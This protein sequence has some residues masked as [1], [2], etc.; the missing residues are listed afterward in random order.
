MS[1]YE[2]CRKTVVPWMVLDRCN[3]QSIFCIILLRGAMMVPKER[4]QLW[5][6]ELVTCRNGSIL[7]SSDP[8][9]L[10]KC[11]SCT[12]LYTH[13]CIHPPSSYFVYICLRVISV[14]Y[15]SSVAFSFCLTLVS[16]HM[17]VSLALFVC[18]SL[19][20]MAVSVAFLMFVS[21]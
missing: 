17:Y 5:S 16:F 2:V 13:G 7:K 6:M 4:D 10:Y 21:F 12:C 3:H 9:S 20:T 8:Q 15:S 18:M 14:T 11:S 1:L 19:L